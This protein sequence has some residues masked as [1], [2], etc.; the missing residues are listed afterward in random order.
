MPVVTIRDPYTWMQSMCR[1]PYEAQFDHTRE[2]C[3]HL[4]PTETDL[5]A[6]PRY[7]KFKYIPVHVIYNRKEHISVRH[8]SLAHYYNEWYQDYKNF[9]DF[10]RLIVR[11]E[12]LIFH[13]EETIAQIC[14]C[15]GGQSRTGS[16]FSHVQDTAKIGDTRRGTPDTGLLG[17]IIK[18]GNASNRRVGYAPV[19]LQAAKDL[20]DPELMKIFGY[21][22]EDP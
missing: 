15:A 3:P 1:Q 7:E 13:G 21:K 8:D 12:D 14:E 4:I 22:Y 18:Y 19:Q 11:M 9:T 16:R 20:L 6:H 2:D 17:A 10:P 5:K